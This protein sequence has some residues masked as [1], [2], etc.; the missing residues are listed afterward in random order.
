MSDTK[1]FFES[2]GSTFTFCGVKFYGLGC[3]KY[4]EPQI[5][6]SVYVD[7][8]GVMHEWTF[9]DRDVDQLKEENPTSDILEIKRS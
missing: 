3:G 7:R 4:S 1:K 6:N 8:N 2:L 9:M 5:L